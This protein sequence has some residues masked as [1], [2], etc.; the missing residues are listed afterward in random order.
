MLAEARAAAAEASDAAASA[1]VAL[2]RLEK[3]VSAAEAKLANELIP[4]RSDVLARIDS[5]RRRV[6]LMPSELPPVAS[7]RP[8]LPDCKSSVLSATIDEL[9]AVQESDGGF[10]DWWEAHAT[11][12]RQPSASGFSPPPAASQWHH[13]Q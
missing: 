4:L 5:L 13:Y 6:S 9:T 8:A 1:T 11:A 2:D 12:P 7:P 3:A 10:D